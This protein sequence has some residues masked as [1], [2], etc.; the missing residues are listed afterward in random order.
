MLRAISAAITAT[1]FAVALLWA[2]SRP[3]STLDPA[4]IARVN[5]IYPGFTEVLEVCEL[6]LA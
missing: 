1:L 5:Q 4:V 3:A 6:L 2:Q